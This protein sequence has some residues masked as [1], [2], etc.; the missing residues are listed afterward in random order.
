M[1]A[2]STQPRRTTRHV[3]VSIGGTLVANTTRAIGLRKDVGMEM[4]T[5]IN[6][7]TRCP[8]KGDVAYCSSS[9]QTE[10]SWS[11]ERITG[12]VVVIEERA[13]DSFRS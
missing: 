7:V 4:L 6:S 9:E 8:I 3:R 13:N 12:G 5:L 11:Y 1:P 10:A 2:P